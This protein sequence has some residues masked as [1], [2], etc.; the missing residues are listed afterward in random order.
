MTLE[1]PEEIVEASTK[2][3]EK[4]I[5]YSAPKVGKT[6]L[7]AGLKNNLIID[8]E[9]GSNFVS[10]LKIKATTYQELHSICEK[11][12]EKGRPYKYITLDTATALEAMCLPL[13][14]KLYQQTP[15]GAAYKGEIL[16]LPNGAGYKYLRDAYEMMINKVQ[17]CADRIILLGHVKDKTIERQGKEV[18]AREL[19]LT[20]KLSSIT[21]SKADAIGF[22]YR[23]GNKNILTFETS[24]DIICGA[25]PK[26]LRNKQIVISE[27]DEKDNL[28]THWDKIFID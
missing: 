19:D 10:A 7:I 16:N 12:K 2:S 20:G 1:L 18:Q 6:A 3:P 5:I 22:L 21:C 28:T 25:R 15:M 4:L 13:A 9:N 26:H 14:L 24:N 11:I 23:D 8:L 17:E 27:M